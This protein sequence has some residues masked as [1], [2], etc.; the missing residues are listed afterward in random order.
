M[1]HPVAPCHILLSRPFCQSS[2]GAR[3]RE[4]RRSAPPSASQSTLNGVIIENILK[5]S[6]NLYLH[7]SSMQFKMPNWRYINLS[8]FT[9]K[10][11]LIIMM[12]EKPRNMRRQG[13]RNPGT[14]DVR[15]G[16]TQGHALYLGRQVTRGP[17]SCLVPGT[18]SDADPKVM[19]CTCDVRWWLT[20]GNSL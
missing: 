4:G 9:A 20:Q 3:G 16:E 13:R 6:L 12:F 14:C 2:W 17:G 7:M 15:E 11:E 5:W 1:D 10:N 18:S 8:L 19:F